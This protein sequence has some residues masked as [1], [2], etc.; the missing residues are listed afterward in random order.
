ML[1]ELQLSCCNDKAI[2]ELSKGNFY[3]AQSIL[4]RNLKLYPCCLTYNNLGVYYS[5]YGM[6]HYNGQDRSAKKLGLR[7]LLK[8][9]MYDHNWKNQ[10]S[11]A[12]A[13]CEVD[14]ISGALPLFRKAYKT[15]N[16]ERISYNIG[17]CLFM[18]RKWREAMC[19]FQNLCS[20]QSVDIIISNGGQNPYLVMAYCALKQNDIARCA[21]YIREYRKIWTNEEKYDVFCLRY[22]CG[23]YKDA[24]SECKELLEEWY[25]SWTLLAMIADCVQ[26]ASLTI[27]SASVIPLEFQEEWRD[28]QENLDKRR[29]KIEEYVYRPPFISM[30][31]FLTE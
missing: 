25:P 22:F 13:L 7:Y 14:S 24:L 16:D 8:A 19:V 5:Q 26:K 21:H 3:I 12:T 9:T 2:S 18:T 31:Y 4:R 15:N 11:A 30:Y 23:L 6:Q 27:I 28:V 20:S 29:K 10:V 17:V 1:N